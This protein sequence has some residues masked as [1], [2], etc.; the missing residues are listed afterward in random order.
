MLIRPPRLLF[1]MAFDPVTVG[2]KQLVVAC[3]TSMRRPLHVLANAIEMGKPYAIAGPQFR[4]TTAARVV[5]LQGSNVCASTR[6]VV[7]TPTTAGIPAT[8]SEFCQDLQTQSPLPY[9]AL[10]LR[11]VLNIHSAASGV[12][13]P[14]ASLTICRRNSSGSLAKCSHS[15]TL[16]SGPNGSSL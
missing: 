13:M 4:A 1:R 7:V 12:K 8:P 15:Q 2:A 9:G 14:H 5:N 3:D 10:A 16:S 6:A 11:Q